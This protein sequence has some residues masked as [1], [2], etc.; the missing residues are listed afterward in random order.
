MRAAP[1]VF[2]IFNAS[3]NAEARREAGR[4]EMY[5]RPDALPLP[6]EP[7]TESRSLAWLTSLARR[8]P[9]ARARR[10]AG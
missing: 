2:D 9:A 4:R 6:E 7:A 5:R 1:F 10:A 8:R 3:G